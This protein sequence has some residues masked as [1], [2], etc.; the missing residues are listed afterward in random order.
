MSV[1]KILKN[2]LVYGLGTFLINATGFLLI[3][4]Y[5][6]FLTPNDYGIVST[7]GIIVIIFTTFYLLGQDSAVARFFFDY[8]DE[9]NR[10]RYFSTIWFFSIGFSLLLSIL[11]TFFGRPIFERIFREI[12]FYPFG[13]IVIWTCFFSLFEALPLAIFRSEE[14]ALRF[15]MVT[16]FSFLVRIGL[17]IYFIAFLKRG[18]LGKLQAELLW[19]ALFSIFFIILMQ[20][21]INFRFSFKDLNSSLKFGLP[22]VPHDLSL[23]SLN[24]ADRLFLQYL[25]SF[26]AV[27]IYALGYNLSLIINFVSTSIGK[28]WTPHFFGSAHQKE[29]KDDYAKMSTYY[30]AIVV[31]V[32]LGLAV[33]SRE[34]IVILSTPNYY[35]AAKIVPIAVLGYIFHSFYKVT[36][37]ILHYVKKTRFIGYS[38][39]SAAILNTILNYILI[40]RHGI[41]G[42]AWA[43][44]ISFA[45]LSLVSFIYSRAFYQVR[46]EKTRLFKIFAVGSAIYFL[47]KWI[48]LDSLYFSLFVKS[49][50]VLVFPLFLYFTNFFTQEEK[51]KFS[52]IRGRVTHNL[53]KVFAKV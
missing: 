31:L 5:T 35:E 40:K 9:K 19:A 4:F 2:S 27:G 29:T 13:V 47:S 17:L 15:S 39:F 24:L 6:R 30:M 26:R 10:R 20:R 7:L 1:L 8:K 52:L 16:Y 28:A 23:W 48:Q 32:G 22:L 41:M 3:P 34:L 53:L 45:F 42:A 21:Y 36:A 43:T 11:L 38:T 50:L 33:L 14:K 12:N 37:R 25:I 46:F 51:L 18:A 49:A 44:L